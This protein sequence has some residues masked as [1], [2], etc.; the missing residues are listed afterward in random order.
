MIKETFK[1]SN[2]IPPRGK[3]DVLASLM[4]EVGGTSY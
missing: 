1:V 4:E 2:I 3:Y